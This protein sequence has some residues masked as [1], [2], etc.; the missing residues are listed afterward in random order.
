MLYTHLGLG[1]AAPIVPMLLV[2][3]AVTFVLNGQWV[4]R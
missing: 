3:P 4:F 2:T 1:R